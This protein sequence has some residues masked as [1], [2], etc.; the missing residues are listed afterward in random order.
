MTPTNDD[1]TLDSMFS[2]TAGL[3]SETTTRVPVTVPLTVPT[4]TNILLTP[5]QVLAKPLVPPFLSPT[6][7]SPTTGT[8]PVI[9]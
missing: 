4:Q 3:E 8:A 1:L 9:S 7:A 6:L 2:L 5:G